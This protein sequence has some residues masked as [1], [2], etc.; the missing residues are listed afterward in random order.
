MKP[1]LR[2]IFLAGVIALTS[3]SG[4]AGLKKDAKKIA[5]VMCKNI[6]AMSYL[7]AANPADSAKIRELLARGKQAEVE[8]AVLY[9]EFRTKYKEKIKDEKFSKEFAAELRKAMLDCKYLSK[10][11]RANFE[12]E[13]NN[14]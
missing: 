7:K 3:C 1:L 14:Q 5:E 8:M 4:N 10:E 12:T 2:I 6:E 11:D 13:I 9:Q